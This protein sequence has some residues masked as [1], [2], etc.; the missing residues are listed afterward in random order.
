MKLFQKL[1]L[2]PAAIGLFAPITASAS[3]ANLMDV[4]SYSQV[5]VEVTQDTFKPLSTKNP[6][7][8]GG[9]GLGNNLSSDFDEDSFSSTT[10]ATFS[11]NFVLGAVDS[12]A[13]ETTKFASDYGID[14]S[15]SFTGNDSL[16]VAL[17]MG[18]G[19]GQIPDADL[20]TAASLVVDSISYT[21]QLGDKLTMFVSLGDGSSGSSLYSSA[22]LYGGVTD[23]M[24][25]CGVANANL[26]ENFGSAFGFRFDF[27]D[28]LSIS[29]AVEGQGM[30]KKGILS[31]FPVEWCPSFKYHC[32]PQ[33][34][35]NFLFSPKIPVNSKIILFHGNPEPFDAIHG[36]SRSW[37]R[38]IKKTPWIEKFWSE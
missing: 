27:T 5:D 9:E 31:F 34:P 15:T 4:S 18:N 26:D 1:L 33:F 36:R 28:S 7:L 30:D 12:T 10:T 16:D 24:D 37:Y 25:D 6:L 19:G 35:L 17:V 29:A 23:A 20:D 38:F 3:E 21:N 11:S 14:V 22:C 32:V 13:D 8:A 2:G